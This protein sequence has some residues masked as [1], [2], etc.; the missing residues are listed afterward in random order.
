MLVVD[1]CC[2]QIA[3][4]SGG[5]ATQY[6]VPTYINGTG[7]KRTNESDRQRSLRAVTLSVFSGDCNKHA[8]YVHRCTPW[9]RRVEMHLDP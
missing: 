6:S 7:R 8:K 1:D 4:W 9:P 5:Q 3:D 2:S